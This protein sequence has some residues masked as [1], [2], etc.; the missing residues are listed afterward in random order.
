MANVANPRKVFQY[1]ILMNGIGNFEC[2]K[3]TLPEEEIEK[4][5]HGETNHDVKTPGRVSY[6]DLVVE[7]LKPTVPLNP[8]ARE[9][10]KAAQNVLTGGGLLPSALKEILT[11]QALDSSGTTVVETYSYD[12]AWLCKLSQNDFDRLMSDNQIETCTF[13]VDKRIV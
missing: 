9:K 6:T 12:G 2:Q 3:L 10:L 13:S 8:E 7:K 11:V 4:V 5:P 1:R